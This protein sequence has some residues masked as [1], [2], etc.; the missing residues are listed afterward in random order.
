VTKSFLL[1]QDLMNA[2]N[3]QGDTEFILLFREIPDIES[4]SSS[5]FMSR[6]KKKS[7]LLFC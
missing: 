3:I 2:L 7:L 4:L 6:R 5:R 1:N